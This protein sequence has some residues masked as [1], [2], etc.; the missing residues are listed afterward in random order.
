MPVQGEIVH[1][2]IL[3]M[4]GNRVFATGLPREDREDI[5]RSSMAWF[6]NPPLWADPQHPEFCLQAAWNWLVEQLPT[7]GDASQDGLSP[8]SSDDDSSDDDSSEDDSS[9]DD[10]SGAGFTGSVGRE[11]TT[12]RLLVNDKH[13]PVACLLREVSLRLEKIHLIEGTAGADTTA[14]AD[15]SPPKD[16]G[17][18][19]IADHTSTAANTEFPYDGSI[20][21]RRQV[22]THVF[23]SDDDF[24]QLHLHLNELSDFAMEEGLARDTSHEAEVL[25]TRVPGL[26]LFG[27]ILTWKGF[28]NVACRSLQAKVTMFERIALRI[29]ELESWIQRHIS[30]G[31]KDPLGMLLFSRPDDARLQLLRDAGFLFLPLLVM[32]Y[33]GSSTRVGRVN[34]HI[35]TGTSTA[36]NASISDRIADLRFLLGDNTKLDQLNL[37]MERVTSWAIEAGF[38]T[39]TNSAV[40]CLRNNAAGFSMFGDF[41]DWENRGNDEWKPWYAFVQLFERLAVHILELENY[42][43]P[44]TAIEIQQIN[45][46]L[47]NAYVSPTDVDHIHTLQRS[48][49]RY[50]PIFI[51]FCQGAGTRAGRENAN[52]GPSDTELPR[53]EDHMANI[54]DALLGRGTQPF[55]DDVVMQRAHDAGW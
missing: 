53:H 30:A 41:A 20:F 21:E 50:I 36:A 29:L 47:Q 23:N 52:A 35:N 8:D 3:K 5:L 45:F 33:Q 49:F 25:R 12:K 6:T 26:P 24:H 55:L 1:P 19:G 39:D 27:D 38:A 42:I 4:L 2:V 37:H 13:D 40:E 14:A 46:R 18:I 28:Y 31:H 48:G 15:A 17:S 7:T 11:E 43:N 16:D 54:A 9:D 32:A 44:H 10:G 22:T 34:P 51:L